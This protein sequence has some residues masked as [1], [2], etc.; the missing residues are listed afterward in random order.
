MA[1]KIREIE[2]DAYEK[3]VLG[4]ELA[5]LDF[6]STECP[7]C[8]A[9]AAKYEPLSELYGDDIRFFKIFRQGNRELAEKLGV[10]G[11]P[12][13][14]FYK[15]GEVVGDKLAGGIKRSVLT[16]KPGLSSFQ[17]PGTGDT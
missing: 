7:P 8:E 4:A 6:Y 9:L 17:R 10:S 2:Q 11:S 13:V 5:V 1:G 15:N 16:K 14:L 3:E 12:T